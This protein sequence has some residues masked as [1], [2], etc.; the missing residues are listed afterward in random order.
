M[1]LFRNLT[2]KEGF[3]SVIFLVTKRRCNHFPSLFDFFYQKFIPLMYFHLINLE[4]NIHLNIFFPFFAKRDSVCVTTLCLAIKIS[5]HIFYLSF[6]L[7]FR[8][9]WL[10]IFLYTLN[11]VIKCHLTF[12]FKKLAHLAI[13]P[14]HICIYLAAWTTALSTIVA[15][16]KLI[17]AHRFCV[18]LGIFQHFPVCLMLCL[19]T[20]LSLVLKF[21]MAHKWRT[22]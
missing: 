1:D 9:S 3:S 21:F 15:F 4:C 2:T 7:K 11:F 18:D 8:H 20:S 17:T 12:L 6:W 13:F 5:C 16:E 10:F 22:S 19:K 14:P